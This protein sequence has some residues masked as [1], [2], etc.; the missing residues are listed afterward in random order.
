L[1]TKMIHRF[2]PLAV[3]SIAILLSSLSCTTNSTIPTPTP[4]LQTKTPII[5]MAEAIDAATT[6]FLVGSQ[7]NLTGEQVQAAK[8]YL[9][10]AVAVYHPATL[11][12]IIWWCDGYGWWEVKITYKSLSQTLERTYRV[13]AGTGKVWNMQ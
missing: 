3:I 13:H 8:K 11:D 10:P 4:T 5:S 2:I 12:N 9:L 1:K 7:G 6:A